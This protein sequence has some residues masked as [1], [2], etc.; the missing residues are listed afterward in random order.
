[1]YGCADRAGKSYRLGT[2]GFCTGADR[3]GPVAL[4]GE[5]AAY[6]VQRCGVDT[7]TA[8]TVVRRLSDGAVLHTAPA[9]SRFPGAE[10]YQ[11]L[12]AVV[13]KADGAVAWIGEARSI[14]G[15]GVVIEVHR[16]DG[17]GQAQLDHGTGIA[18]RS[19]R[20]RGSRLSWLHAGHTRTAI[21]S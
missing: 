10:S 5:V 13:V 21:L 15:R 16:Y 4:S 1:V 6:G 3:V 2:S 11:S 7:G 14:I 17:G 12:T 9:T 18:A 19:L 8:Q 20:L